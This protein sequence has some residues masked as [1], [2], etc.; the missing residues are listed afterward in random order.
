M[1]FYGYHGAFA[2]ERELGQR[3]EVDVELHLNLKVYTIVKDIVEEREFNLMEAIAE[4][5]AEE[6]LSAYTLEEVVVR[7]RKPNPPSGGIMDYLEA[8]VRRSADKTII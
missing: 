4:T 2:A 7:V 3:I 1:V 6:I 8:E 5:I